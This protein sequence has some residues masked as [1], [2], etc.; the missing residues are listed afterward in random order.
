RTFPSVRG[1]GPRHRGRRN[2][3]RPGRCSAGD[4]ALKGGHRDS[5]TSKTWLR[6]EVLKR[7]SCGDGDLVGNRPP[8]ASPWHISLPIGAYHAIPESKPQEASRRHEERI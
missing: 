7:D 4:E 6:V 3:R 1:P 5:M 2:G 8:L